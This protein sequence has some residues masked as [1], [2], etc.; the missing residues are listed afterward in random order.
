M[1]PGIGHRRLRPA[2]FKLE[3]YTQHDLAAIPPPDPSVPSPNI[4]RPRADGGN[5]VTRLPP[6]LT[7]TILLYL[8]LNSLLT[9]RLINTLYRTLIDSLHPYTLLKQHAPHTLRILHKV[10]LASQ[11]P[12]HQL[13]TEFRH[14]HCRACGAFGPLVFLPTLTRCC[15][16]CLWTQTRFQ[17]ARVGFLVDQFPGD[18]TPDEL[19]TLVSLLKQLPTVHVFPGPYGRDPLHFDIIDEPIGLVSIAEAEKATVKWLGTHERFRESIASLKAPLQRRGQGRSQEPGQRQDNQGRTEFS[20]DIHRLMEIY[21][22]AR[23]R[24]MGMG[25][26]DLPYWDTQ[27]QMAESGIYCSPCTLQK[28]YENRYEQDDGMGEEGQ[29]GGA[30]IWDGDDHGTD[31]RNTTG[32]RVDNAAFYM[33]DICRHFEECERLRK[34]YVFG[35]KDGMTRGIWNGPDF[36][37]SADGSIVYDHD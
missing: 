13:Y 26:T 33:G 7:T 17:V 35:M 15:D 10:Q 34:G 25:A 21:E 3:L 27:R 28:E 12:L 16:R 20:I 8:D 5:L 24:W 37:I 2:R 6:E 36:W 4:T 14:P 18:L 1:A 30:L 9:L 29:G 31:A 32:P 19:E 23:S 22:M 11:F